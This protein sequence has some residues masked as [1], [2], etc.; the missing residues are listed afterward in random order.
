[1]RGVRRTLACCDGRGP[2]NRN[3]NRNLGAPTVGSQQG[4]RGTTGARGEPGV[5][6]IIGCKRVC[7]WPVVC[8]AAAC[9]EKRCPQSRPTASEPASPRPA[10][11]HNLNIP[12]TNPAFTSAIPSLVRPLCPL[13]PYSTSESVTLVAVDSCPPNGRPG[14]WHQVGWVFLS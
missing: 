7:G 2:G 10:K 1:M 4:N 12:L 13:P 5:G 8:M 6:A 11:R 3:R 9:D 14:Q